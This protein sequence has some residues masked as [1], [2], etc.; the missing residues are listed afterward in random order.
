V[1]GHDGPPAANEITRVQGG[2]HAQ[3]QFEDAALPDTQTRHR[4]DSLAIGTGRPALPALEQAPDHRCLFRAQGCDMFSHDA[5]NAAAQTMLRCAQ[6]NPQGSEAHLETTP[7]K[8]FFNIPL[9]AQQ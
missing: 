5:A 7:G 3:P 2:G 1:P 4:K 8:S 6:H 9:N